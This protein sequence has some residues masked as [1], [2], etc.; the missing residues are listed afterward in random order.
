MPADSN[1][2]TLFIGKGKYLNLTAAVLP[3]RGYYK[4]PQQT[5]CG[6]LEPFH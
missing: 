5:G 2:V 1:I 6:L 3:D 4:R